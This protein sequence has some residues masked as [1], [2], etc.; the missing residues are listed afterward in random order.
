MLV[1]L[2][3]ILSRTSL[4]LSGS[5]G[6]FSFFFLF[7]LKSG[8]LAITTCHGGAWRQ[9]RSSCDDI[10]N[11]SLPVLLESEVIRLS[12]LEPEVHG[13]F[14]FLCSLSI[15]L[16]LSGGAIGSSCSGFS[17]GGNLH[18]IMGHSL[19]P[20]SRVFHDKNESVTCQIGPWVA[21][22]CFLG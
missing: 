16:Q 14:R 15:D 1:F 4:V 9:Q 20:K 17:G 11:P 6:T 2:S 8:S 13:L 10:G 18:K 12:F 7:C 5:L 22:I 19:H 21:M 3:F